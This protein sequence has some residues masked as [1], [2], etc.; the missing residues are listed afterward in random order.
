M[1]N[2]IF[3]N[4]EEKINFSYYTAFKFELGECYV[5][6]SR[7]AYLISNKYLYYLNNAIENLKSI[8]YGDD[9]EIQLYFSPTIPHFY[10]KMQLGTHCL[11]MFKIPNGVFPL[12][13][14]IRYFGGYLEG[15]HVCWIISRLLNIV[16]FIH[17]N[18]KV[19]NG[20]NIDNCFISPSNHFVALYGGWWY[21]K[22]DGKTMYGMPTSVYNIL[23][24]ETKK[25]KKSNIITDINSVKQVGRII[26]GIETFGEDIGL[27]RPLYSFLTSNNSSI[28]SVLKEWEEVKR[29]S[30]GE[31]KFMKMD[32]DISKILN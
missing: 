32:V 11:V 31:P 21:S 29:N 20:I 3:R 2:I 24:E 26:S 18:G 14:I 8:Y 30:Y 1:N 25:S 9:D 17:K 7:I 6:E 23:D 15:E 16:E 28:D 10:K 27:P 4:N 5:S 12:D 13:S 22:Q 19:H